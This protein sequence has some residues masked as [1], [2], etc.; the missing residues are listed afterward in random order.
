LTCFIRIAR[1]VEGHLAGQHLVEDDAQ[2]VQVGAGVAAPG[3]A[4][5]GGHITQ[6]AHQRPGDGVLGGP[7]DLGDAEVGQD[8]LALLA[9]HDVGRFQ[10]PVDDAGLVGIAQSGEGIDQDADHFARRHAPAVDPVGGQVGLQRIALEQLH[11]HEVQPVLHVEVVDLDDVGVAEGGHGACLPA[12]TRQEFLL[13]HQVGAQHLDRHVPVELR[14]VGLVDLGHPAA[15]ER[16]EDAVF[17]ERLTF[18]GGED[19]VLF[20]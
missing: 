2:G 7:D 5:F 14:V 15:T 18:Q 16:L 9:E 13:L 6:R 19:H 4:L 10:V 1:G 11:H 20:R 17:A 12:E 8:G 3:H